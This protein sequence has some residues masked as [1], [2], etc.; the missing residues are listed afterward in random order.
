MYEQLREVWN[1]LISE[2][3]FAITEAEVRGN[4]IKTYAAAPPSL[5]EVWLASAAHGDKD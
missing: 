3:P 2:G 1:E 4:T 5:R